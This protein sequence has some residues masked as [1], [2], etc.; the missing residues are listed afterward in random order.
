VRAPYLTADAAGSTAL[1][2]E[3]SATAIASIVPAIAPNARA[4]AS[5]VTT[6][7]SKVRTVTPKVTTDDSKVTTVTQKVTTDDSKVS[8][9][10][11]NVRT[12][13]LKPH[14]FR[15]KIHAVSGKRVVNSEQSLG[16]KHELTAIAASAH[17]Y[18]R[19]PAVHCPLTTGHCNEPFPPE[20]SGDWKPLYMRRFNNKTAGKTAKES[21]MKKSL[22][23]IALVMA[24][25]GAVW[26]VDFSAYP[27]CIKKGNV[28]LN[29]G[30]GFG[31]PLYG[32][33]VIPPLSASLDFAS[34][35]GG[36]PLTIGPYVGFNTSKYEYN[37]TIY[38]YGNYGYTYRYTGLVAGGRLGYH[39]NLDAKN[40]DAYANFCL[41]YYWFSAKAEYTG[42]F[43]NYG[44]KPQPAA[45]DNVFYNLNIGCRY[46]L[47]GGFGVFAELGYSALS[48][49][50]AG[51]TF[52]I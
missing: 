48:Y 39:P 21:S 41:G 47:G 12:V 33:T 15:N 42:S 45:Y 27:D 50:T 38:S 34:N 35:L 10:T 13:G 36:L 8:A 44:T 22:L 32:T 1:P 18:R 14:T 25:A 9:I 24:G 7:D 2:V 52:K 23:V 49:F 19:K 4:V 5:K 3:T 20:E 26:A 28:I 6:N 43:Y 16:G 46:F 40:L 51:L 17:L 29:A 11:S 31:T 37:S 30:I